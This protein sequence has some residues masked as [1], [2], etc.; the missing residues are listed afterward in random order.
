MD[1][2]GMAGGPTRTPMIPL[3]ADEKKELE[4]DL[5][6]VGLID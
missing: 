3:T 4:G 2:M 6:T 5:R 1:L